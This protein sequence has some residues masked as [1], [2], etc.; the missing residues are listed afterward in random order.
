MKLLLGE[1]W[2]VTEVLF[3]YLFRRKNMNQFVGN[4]SIGRI[5]KWVLQE[6]KG[7]LILRT[8]NISYPLIRTRACVY[9][10]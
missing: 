6:N 8:R 9:Q 3:V 10:E 4:K 2:A 7:R 1:K 5:S